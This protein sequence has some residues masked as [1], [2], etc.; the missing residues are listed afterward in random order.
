MSQHTRGDSAYLYN[1]LLFN[2]RSWHKGPL[3]SLF[4]L[5]LVTLWMSFAAC[6]TPLLAELIQWWLKAE[7][8]EANAKGAAVLL[9]LFLAPL[10]LTWG[11]HRWRLL[12]HDRFLREVVRRFLSTVTP[13][14]DPKAHGTLH[15]SRRYAHMR[16]PLL[17]E[18]GWLE[19]DLRRPFVLHLTRAPGV[20]R[21]KVLVQVDLSQA[22]QEG[23]AQRRR[24]WFSLLA[25]PSPQLEALPP[26]VYN[27][28]LCDPDALVG[29][30]WPAL[31]SSVAAH[32]GAL[33]WSLEEE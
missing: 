9:L 6:L 18:G 30:L 1:A 33:N 29:W 32:G 2:L 23:A 14:V 10:G 3:L 25:E 15:F 24:L 13:F 28:P 8:G 4:F 20:T 31:R 26:M 16:L 19:V 12:S 22:T 5:H 27:A 7:G 21:G 11:L 17:E